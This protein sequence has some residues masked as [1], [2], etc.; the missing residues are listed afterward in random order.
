MGGRGS[1]IAPVNVATLSV[2]AFKEISGQPVISQRQR[3]EN[4][5]TKYLYAYRHSTMT[6]GYKNSHPS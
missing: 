3:G 1:E 5:V 4:D 2:F 6:W